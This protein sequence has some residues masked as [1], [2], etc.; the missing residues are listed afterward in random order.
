MSDTYLN[1]LGGPAAGP[2]HIEDYPIGSCI[3]DE[4]GYNVLSFKSKPGAKFTSR[5]HC[6]QILKGLQ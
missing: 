5:E 6:E 1:K 2:F 4:S 3:C